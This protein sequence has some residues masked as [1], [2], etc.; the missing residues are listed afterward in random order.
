MAILDG[1]FEERV[2]GS[3]GFFVCGT[4]GTLLSIYLLTP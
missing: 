1:E 2:S 3:G 4:R